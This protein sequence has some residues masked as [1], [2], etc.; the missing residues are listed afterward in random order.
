MNISYLIEETGQEKRKTRLFL[1]GYDR[2][3]GKRAEILQFMH[4]PN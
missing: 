4:S 1:T 3:T 2:Y